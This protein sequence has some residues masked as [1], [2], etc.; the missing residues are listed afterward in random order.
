V[1]EAA[2]IEPYAPRES[3]EYGFVVVGGGRSG[4]LGRDPVKQP[5]QMTTA[6]SGS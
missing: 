3:M 6:A 1:T 4:V 2:R 5:A